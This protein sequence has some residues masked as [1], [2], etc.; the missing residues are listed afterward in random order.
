MSAA[1]LQPLTVLIAD[2]DPAM[3]RLMVHIVTRAG[4]RTLEA[5]DGRDALT[6]VLAHQPELLI[7]DW[8]MPGLTG[9]ELCRRLRQQE[10][11]SY[12]YSLLVTAKS[13]LD[14]LVEGLEAGADDF[15]TKPFDP[16]GLLARLRA[17]ARTVDMERRLRDQAMLDPLTHAMNR[18]TFIDRLQMEWERA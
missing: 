5:S 6:Q 11:S 8:D 4:Y 3:R 14:E 13:Q 2:D 15:I 18:G 7:T 16:P 1:T 17:G 10:H 12:T 9:V